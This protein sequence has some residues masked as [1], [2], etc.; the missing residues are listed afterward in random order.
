MVA[1]SFVLGAPY[2]GLPSL[3]TAA[4]VASGLPVLLLTV[5]LSSPFH[6]AVTIAPDAHAAVLE[7]MQAAH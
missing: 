7:E 5:G 2:P 1:F 4:L 3:M 6:S